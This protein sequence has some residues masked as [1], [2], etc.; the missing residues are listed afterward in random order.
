MLPYFR[1]I[2]A[3]TFEKIIYKL[4]CCIRQKASLLYLCCQLFV[5]P[6][7]SSNCKKH[8]DLQVAISL[9]ISIPI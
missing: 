1:T 5:I 2:Y 4:L 8:C 6:A 7:R 9:Y 3:K